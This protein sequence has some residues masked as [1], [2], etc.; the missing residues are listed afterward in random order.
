[1]SSGYNKTTLIACDRSQSEEA[2]GFNNE[3]PSAWTNRVGSGLHLKIGDQISVQSTYVSELGA[4]AGQIQIK[5]QSV[6]STTAVIT[7]FENLQRVEALPEKYT[8]VNASNKTIDIDVR[9]DKLDIV[10]SP[11][12]TANG[13]NYIFLPRRYAWDGT[14]NFRTQFDFREDI[15]GQP[16]MGADPAINESVDMGQT[17]AIQRPLN[18]CAADLQIIFK[19]HTKNASQQVSKLSTKN[20]GSKYTLFVRTQTFLGDPATPDILITG[21]AKAGSP[22]IN[23]THG[24]VTTDLLV[25]MKIITQSPAAVFAA[26]DSIIS[27]TS[28][29]ITMSANASANTTSHNE[30]TFQLPTTSSDEFLPP[31]T[32]NS[33]FNA[34]TVESFRDPAVFGDYIP[35]RNLIS[36]NANPGYNSPLDLAVQLTQEINKPSKTEFLNYDL[37][38]TTRSFTEN[39]TLT[40]IKETPA[41][42]AYHC[43]TAGSYQKSYFTNWFDKTDSSWNVDTAYKYLA[44][45]QYLG[46]KRPEI[47]IA[48]MSWMN[49]SQSTFNDGRIGGDEGNEYLVETDPILMT[50]M[51][52]TDENLLRI[53]V[54]FDSQTTAPEIF[55]DFK[56]NGIS[57]NTDVDTR[58]LHM[59]L[60]DEANDKS[61]L[62]NPSD[63]GANVRVDKVP[64]LGYDMY[65]ASLSSSM[66]SFPIFVDYNINSS[67]LTAD[68]VGFTEYGSGYGSSGKMTANY[69]DLAYGFA[70][71]VRRGGVSAG[72][73]EKYYIGFQ[74]TR[75]GGN[76]P[77]HF[78]HANASAAN[79]K[80]IGTGGGR[81]FGFDQHFSAYANS[82]M[83]LSN[84]NFTIRG[85]NFN[86]QSQKIYTIAQGQGNTSLNLDPYQYGLYLG[87]AGAF[88][89]YDENQ[90]RFTISDFH[91][92]ERVGNRF[93]A[94][95]QTKDPAVPTNPDAALECYKINKRM[96]GNNY[97]PEMCPYT[98]EFSGKIGGA[99][100]STADYVSDNPN[101][102]TYT[103]MDAHS[104]LFIEEWL[105]PEKQWDQSLAGIMGFRFDQFN[106]GTESRQTRITSGGSTSDRVRYKPRVLTTHADVNEADLMGYSH[107]IYSAPTYQLTNPVGLS[108]LT[109]PTNAS[110]ARARFITAPI[111][112]SPVKSINLTAERLPSKTLRPYYTIRS[113]ILLENNYL[114]GNRSG[115]TLPIVAITNKANPY[116]DF[117]NGIG[118][119]VVFTNTIDRVITNIRCSIHEPNGELARVDDNSAVIFKIDQQ[120]NA[121]LDLVTQLLESKKKEDKAV[122]AQIEANYPGAPP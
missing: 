6:G 86:D 69:N 111:V 113:D 77:T 8:Q 46:I 17:R 109:F 64:T 15:V 95:S 119:D 47:Y 102:S 43:A 59:N 60:Y 16:G 56:Q 118:G 50:T 1:M 91:T 97:T 30:F 112:I 103:V 105:I 62:V 92:A 3:N 27:L 88:I 36:M 4:Q 68:Q 70:R 45:H 34:C 83:L 5:G 58:L 44:A 65:N 19:P 37:K 75:T 100:A 31:T 63:F 104:G 115:I 29:S 9:D 121:Q 84:G 71:K 120:Q 79:E 41:N 74:F 73:S 110:Y 82:M 23:V 80:Q 89:N 42:K 52:F 67:F 101:I 49:S 66:T 116:G 32:T 24:S 14:K 55:D 122:A 28:T 85:D 78:F 13:E 33:S 26:A 114:G 94:G 25:L 48:G 18:R 107:N 11:Y 61:S 39:R 99:S 81:F 72:Q 106:S 38:D 40:M 90:S 2:I 117:L 51:D 10:V 22:I 76:I 21:K 12:K 98:D 54:F 20:D 108:S 35:V 87:A 53:K 57:V 7:E 96:L 93:D